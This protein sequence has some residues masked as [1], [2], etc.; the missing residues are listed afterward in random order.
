MTATAPTNWAAWRRGGESPARRIYPSLLYGVPLL[1]ALL[2]G[3]LCAAVSG[4]IVTAPSLPFSLPAAEFAFGAP[5][6]FAA[7]LVVAPGGAGPLLFFD[8]IRYRLSDDAECNALQDAL[9]ASRERF[10]WDSI[11]L[12][13]DG[14]APHADVVRFAAEARR[15]G[16]ASVNVAVREASGDDGATIPAPRVPSAFGLSFLPATTAPAAGG[17]AP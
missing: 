16:A 11:T 2:L 10:G 9:A 15:A 1:N 7:T 8:G 13:A 4:R 14:G 12:F 17:S 5:D 3:A 6:D